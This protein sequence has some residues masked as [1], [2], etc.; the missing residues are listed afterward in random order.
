MKGR[1]LLVVRGAE[2][3][4]SMP[5]GHFN[6]IFVQDVN[7]LLAEIPTKQV[8]PLMRVPVSTAAKKFQLESSLNVMREA[9]REGTFVFWNHPAW[10]R[11][12]PD[13]VAR[14]QELHKQFLK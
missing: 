1:D 10:L 2:I 3:T 14:W 6:A 5:Q 12:T 11:Q 4:R 13:G 8:S 9:A 7:G